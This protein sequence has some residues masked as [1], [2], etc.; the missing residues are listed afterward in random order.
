[1]EHNQNYLNPLLFCGFGSE[2]LGAVVGNNSDKLKKC[3]EEFRSNTTAINGFCQF[4]PMWLD[5]IS[6]GA[7]TDIS[8]DGANTANI[9]KSWKTAVDS[10]QTI[11]GKFTEAMSKIL[12][13]VSNQSK[14]NH[15]KQLNVEQIFIQL[16]EKLKMFASSMATISKLSRQ[17]QNTL[18]DA[19]EASGWLGQAVAIW[20]SA[21]CIIAEKSGIDVSSIRN[22]QTP[23]LTDPVRGKQGLFPKLKRTLTG[24]KLDQ[25]VVIRPQVTTSTT[26]V[27][28]QKEV[29]TTASSVSA[30]FSTS[31]E[32]NLLTEEPLPSPTDIPKPRF[33]I[34]RSATV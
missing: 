9:K 3:E 31:T 21:Y 30:K 22:Q 24:T 16:D 18:S 7:L 17:R 6:G 5:G 20:K 14:H 29:L 26:V 15:Q 25:R 12:S 23:F 10:I 32:N 19:V 33:L 13:Q 4:V 8:N 1:M 27:S 11:N 2:Y 34:K 28:Q